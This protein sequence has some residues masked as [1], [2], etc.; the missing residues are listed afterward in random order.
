MANPK[1]IY[2]ACSAERQQYLASAETLANLTLPDLLAGYSMGGYTI[3]NTPTNAVSNNG[4]IFNN[5]GT[6]AI[7]GLASSLQNVLFPSN[8]DWFRLSLDTAVKNSVM[9]NGVSE[10]DIDNA[11]SEQSKLVKEFL[12]NINYQSVVGRIFNRLLVE[13]NVVIIVTKDGIRS[14][15]MRNAGIKR[16]EGK[17][18]FVAWWEEATDENGKVEKIYYLVDYKTNEIWK[19]EEN[20]QRAKKITSG[21]SAKRVFVSTS[22]IPDNGSYCCS[23]GYRHYGLIYTINNFSYH[24][25][26]AASIASKSIL[27]IDENSGLSPQQVTSLQGGQAIVGNATALTWLDSAQKIT[28][29]SFVQQYVENL[30][31]QLSKA[32]ALDILNFTQFPQPRTATEIAAISTSL[33]SRIASL[34]Q[35]VQTTFVK[36]LVSA[37]LDI[38]AEQG[39]F[40]DLLKNINPVVTS[41]TSS[42]DRQQEYQKLLQGLAVI[43]QFDPSLSQRIDSIKLLETFTAVTGID[44]ESYIREL[45]DPSTQQIQTGSQNGNNLQN[46]Q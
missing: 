16:E 34:A 31:Q 24:L 25:M 33:D 40:P 21:L 39:I 22:S 10:T 13:D 18:R 38:L 41:G 30:K 37:V 1:K 44:T 4:G 14:V 6:Q 19:Q 11:L 42:Y 23:Y 20:N 45:P 12:S 46:N 28:D 29:W 15:P 2:E 5:A 43:S 35:S 32:F 36:S 17:L 8:V 26:R 3:T 9:A 7:T 27:F